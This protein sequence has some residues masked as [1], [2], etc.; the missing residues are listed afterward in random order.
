MNA[1]RPTAILAD[2]D[3]SIRQ[4]YRRLIEHDGRLELLGAAHDGLDAVDLAVRTRP[5]VAILDV[6]MPRATGIEATRAI[7]EQ[8]DAA[9]LVVTTFDLDRDVRA[10]IRAGANG[11]LLKTEAADQLVDAALA[12][13]GG[14]RVYNPTAVG[15]LVEALA[16][17]GTPSVAPRAATG[18]E[19]DLSDREI[20]VLR[21]VATGRSNAEI[22]DELFL[23]VSTV[24]SHMRSILTKIDATNRTQAVVWAYEH[25]I[26]RPGR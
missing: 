6:R 7:V 5:D 23:S 26:V 15:L 25:S 11:F 1:D 17:H 3:L 13:A 16:D 2:D 24:R 9:V 21:L 22:A 4:D 14:E 20:D 10:A 12:V 19:H 18:A 8:T